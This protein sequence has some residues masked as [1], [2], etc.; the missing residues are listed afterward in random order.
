MT[1]NSVS[2]LMSLFSD[3][4]DVNDVSNFVY[5]CVCVC[6][7]AKCVHVFVCAV[8]VTA[9]SRTR[10]QGEGCCLT[11]GQRSGVMRSPQTP[12]QP[13]RHTHTYQNHIKS[14]HC[15]LLRSF[16]FALIDTWKAIQGWSVAFYWQTRAP[17]IVNRRLCIAFCSLAE[18]IGLRA[19]LLVATLA[20]NQTH[21]CLFDP[22]HN[23]FSHWENRHML[24]TRTLLS[25][26]A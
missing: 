12:R 17:V 4:S 14:G 22:F 25:S 16:H 26:W 11:R 20:N 5:L 23:S 3:L 1:D 6:M 10:L 19:R 2:V 15:L 8:D 13:V 7:H 21:A 24:K 18:L 9:A